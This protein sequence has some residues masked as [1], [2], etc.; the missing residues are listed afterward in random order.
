[1]LFSLSKVYISADPF[2]GYRTWL[3]V[4]LTVSFLL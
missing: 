2:L 4:L 3:L 1:M